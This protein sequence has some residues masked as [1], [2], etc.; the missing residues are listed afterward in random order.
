[1][2]VAVVTIADAN[3]LP[4]ACCTL[5][6]CARAGKVQANL[7]LIADNASADE[8][9]AAEKFLAEQNITAS[10]I[11]RE[12]QPHPG[13][14]RERTPYGLGSSATYTRLH[15]DEYFDISWQRILYLDADVR[16]VS[17]LDPLIETDLHGNP[18]GAAVQDKGWNTGP[19]FNA[20]VLLFA[21][22]TGLAAT[23]LRE[24]S[25]FLIEN[26]DLCRFADQDALNYVFQG[27]WR[28]IDRRWNFINAL[29]RQFPYRRPYIKHPTTKNKPWQRGRRPHMLTDGIWYWRVL[30]NSPWPD[31]AARPTIKDFVRTAQWYWTNRGLWWDGRDDWLGSVR[32]YRPFEGA[33]VFVRGL[34]LKSQSEWHA[35]CKSGKKPEDVPARPDNTY[36]EEGW[37]GWSDWLG[38]PGKTGAGFP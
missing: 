26:P 1:M 31:F 3:Y 18:L 35:Y 38:V 21:W 5:L 24:T 20:G 25:R 11:R 30:R 6:S 28:P 23:L 37:T 19:Y 9:G 16:V 29:A 32:R 13:Y 10:I 2:K 27:H 8:I 12:S 22:E 7:Y 36:I 15:L 34:G 4:A 17:P 33:R 14:Q